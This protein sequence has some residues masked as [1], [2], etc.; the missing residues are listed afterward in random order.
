MSL[1]VFTI[2]TI[3][4]M[5]HGIVCRHGYYN[6]DVASCHL[7]VLQP[8]IRCLEKAVPRDRDLA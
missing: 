4:M 7:F 1:F 3:M 6:Y 8:F 2:F 5:Y